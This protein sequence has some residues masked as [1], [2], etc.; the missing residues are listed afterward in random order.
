MKL[1]LEDPKNIIDRS[2]IEWVKE[3]IRDKI[4]SDIDPKKLIAWDEFL[5]SYPEYKSIYKKRISALDVITAGAMNLDYSSSA[6]N[7]YIFINR[8]IFM[9]GLDRI[10]VESICKLINFGNQESSGYPIFTN[11]FEYFAKNISTYIDRYLNGL[12]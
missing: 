11:T 8:N 3:K 6:S 12:G 4:I 10:K 5:N 1:H 7:I 2:F 9:P